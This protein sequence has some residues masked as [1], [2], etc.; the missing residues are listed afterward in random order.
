MIK[1]F[2]INETYD[3]DRTR[4]RMNASIFTQNESTNDPKTPNDKSL[5][6]S[7]I[8]Q[9]RDLDGLE[10]HDLTSDKS[11]NGNTTNIN[12]ST[13][14][15]FKSAIVFVKEHKKDNKKRIRTHKKPKVPIFTN[16]QL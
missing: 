13:D 5:H 2:E 12:D 15:A 3:T 1:K 4:S 9:N 16:H 7:Q 14:L 10:D 8:S 6:K 11:D